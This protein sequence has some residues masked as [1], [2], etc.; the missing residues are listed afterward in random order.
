MAS[1]SLAPRTL[2]FTIEQFLDLQQWK[3]LVFNDA[4]PLVDVS[5][6]PGD[7]RP[8]RTLCTLIERSGRRRI[9]IGCCPECGHVTYIDRPTQ[10]WIDE[11]YRSTWDADDLDERVN[12]KEAKLATKQPKEKTGV[13]IALGLDVDRTRPVCE[14]GC[15]YGGSLKRLAEAGFARLVGTESSAHRADVVRKV[16][17]FEV[18]TAPFESETTG[19]AL[20]AIAPFSIIYSHHVLEHTYHPDAVIRAAS[21]LQQP[22]DYLIISVPHH[23]L[24]PSMGVLLFLPHLHSFTRASLERV[25]SR[26]GY[27]LCDDSRTHPKNLNLAFRKT[28][29]PVPLAAGDQP[30]AQAVEK[31]VRVLQLGR[32]R[33]Y[34]RRL[35][36]NRRADQAGQIVMWG[37]GALEARHWARVARAHGYEHH[38]SVK[39]TDLGP[40]FTTV[41]E[42]P[43]EIQF[44]GDLSLFYK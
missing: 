34:A 29:A 33:F 38:R 10:A 8:L 30:F 9:R 40:R 28:D 42:S 7:G 15:G 43:L 26:F 20:S 41:D 31:Y 13:K 11:Y 21:R 17:G 22:G 35:W 6:C 44:R 39:V 25:A 16:L 19:A 36:W 27:A 23:P 37:S 5:C 3:P 12:R 32:R 24:E 2:G 1:G 14:I 18:L 4:V